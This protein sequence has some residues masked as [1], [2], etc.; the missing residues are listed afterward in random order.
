MKTEEKTEEIIK[1][2]RRKI[3]FKLNVLPWIIITIMILSTNIYF[4]SKY[5]AAEAILIEAIQK[6][7]AQWRISENKK[8]IFSWNETPQNEIT[9][10]LKQNE[11][12]E[13]VYTLEDD[14][15]A[16]KIGI[17]IETDLSKKINFIIHMWF[18]KNL[19]G[20]EQSNI[21]N[22]QEEI[23]KNIIQS[24]E[25]FRTYNETKNRK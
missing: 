3:F 25:G 15:L 17:K 9:K 10:E 7:I 20:Y 18:Q 21:Q 11:K 22:L 12:R 19:P 23:N 8:I 24:F 13:Y 16:K 5:K 1:K 6:N 14:Q 2:E 4:Y